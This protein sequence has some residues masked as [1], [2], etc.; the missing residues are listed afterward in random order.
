MLRT[1]AAL[2]LLA[3]AACSTGPKDLAKPDGRVFRLHPER[4]AEAGL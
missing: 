2:L 4:W 1:L 3:L